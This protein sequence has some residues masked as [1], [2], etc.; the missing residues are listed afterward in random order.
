MRKATSGNAGEAAVMS[1]F[2]DLGL[3]VLVP[4]GSGQGFDLVVYLGGDR[5]L[6]V[7]CKTAWQRGG[8]LIFNSLKTDHGGDRTYH[9]VADVFGVYFPPTKRVY[10]VPLS[11][12]ASSEGRLR[13]EPARNN[14]RRRIRMAS[15]FESSRWSLSGLLAI[16]PRSAMPAMSAA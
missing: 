14:Q 6:R 12:V 4:F 2:L 16:H 7:Q 11:D 3:D 10:F 15:D 5:F 9:G 13:L 8:C 1:A